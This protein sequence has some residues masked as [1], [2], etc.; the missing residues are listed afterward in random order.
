MKHAER[1]L[2]VVPTG[3]PADARSIHAAVGVNAFSTTHSALIRLAREGRIFSSEQTIH[4]RKYRL[5]Y[6][7]PKSDWIG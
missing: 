6:W 3:K 1:V 4:H 7:R 2:P 5:L